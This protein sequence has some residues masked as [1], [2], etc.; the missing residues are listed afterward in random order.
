[1][2][3]A[4]LGTQGRSSAPEVLKRGSPRDLHCRNCN[5]N[6]SNHQAHTNK[7]RNTTKQTNPNQNK[8]R[9]EE[10]TKSPR[11]GTDQTNKS[12]F[13]PRGDAP[14]PALQAAA[15]TP[16]PQAARG[17]LRVEGSTAGPLVRGILQWA[18][19]TGMGGEAGHL[20]LRKHGRQGPSRQRLR[21]GHHLPPR[22]S[23][24]LHEKKGSK[25]QPK[26]SVPP[27]DEEAEVLPQCHEQTQPG[28][29]Q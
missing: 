24:F 21:T 10:K 6:Q 2:T 26:Q 25:N 12:G 28:P 19:G 20:G 18:A 1:M 17:C 9:L 23:K 8:Q 15:G 4:R 27:G 13:G 7:T 14:F 5:R 3:P 16:A 11:A 22:G 29:G